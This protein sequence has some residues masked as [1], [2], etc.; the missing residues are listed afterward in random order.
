MFEPYLTAGCVLDVLACWWLP[1]GVTG[2]AVPEQSW[3]LKAT[4]K[5]CLYNLL[6]HFLH[7]N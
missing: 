1:C 6:S 2:D 4:A 7:H 3:L 5:P